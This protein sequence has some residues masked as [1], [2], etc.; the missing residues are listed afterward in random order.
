M[1]RCRLCPL[2]VRHHLLQSYTVQTG[3][4]NGRVS[5]A[6]A[7][8]SHWYTTKASSTRSKG[9]TTTNKYYYQE[10]RSRKL[11]IH[12]TYSLQQLHGPCSTA[13]RMDDHARLDLVYTSIYMYSHSWKKTS[14]GLELGQGM[15]DNSTISS[16]IL[17]RIGL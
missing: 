1:S 11:L 9:L 12:Q 5:R 7:R 6:L 3:S 4:V 15:F 8:T 16:C 13:I 2:V 17:H 14:S 10:A